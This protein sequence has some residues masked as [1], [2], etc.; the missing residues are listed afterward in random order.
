MTQEKNL[1]GLRE[2]GETLGVSRSLIK[3]LVRTGKVRSVRINRRV[4]IPASEIQRLATNGTLS[5][6]NST[7]A[8]AYY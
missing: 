4:L 7:E 5:A 3:K 1:F 2:S 8:R 6:G